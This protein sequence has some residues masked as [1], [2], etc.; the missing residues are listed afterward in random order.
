MALE[1]GRFGIE[2]NPRHVGRDSSGLGTVVVVVAAIALVSLAITLFGRL[3]NSRDETAQE[4]AHE[5]VV[6][7]T[8]ARS[9]G[10]EAKAETKASAPAPKPPR[11]LPK[12]A[13]STAIE[14]KISPSLEMR[15]VKV[16]N[17]LMRLEQAERMRDTEMAVTTIEQIRALPGSPAADID[18][19]LARRLGAL[20]LRRLFIS[21]HPQ[22]VKE[23][24]VKRGDSATRIAAE[25]GSTLASFARLNGGNVDRVL[26]GAKLK[27]MNH[28]R[29]NLVVRRR[30]RTADLL[31]NGKFFKRY[32]LAGE[33]TGQDGAY[34]LPEK[35]RS[36]WVERGI[37][38]KLDDR[39]EIE[40]LMPK[41]SSIIV[42][43]M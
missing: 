3:R 39:T 14:R 32:D 36:F 4:Q 18:D 16:R 19:A 43:E 12:A 1:R 42:S 33:V 34:E 22:W 13:I 28:P 15:P 38:L 8:L 31:L 24:T 25:N 10:L 29:F 30:V 37:K 40:M 35:K 6:E 7:E 26:L 11:E 27:V 5:R 17:L 9:Q 2:Y 21:K 20:N 41:G 23:V